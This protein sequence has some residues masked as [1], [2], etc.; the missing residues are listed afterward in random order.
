MKIEFWNRDNNTC[1]VLFE[2]SD[3]FAGKQVR[4][5]GDYTSRGYYFKKTSLQWLVNNGESELDLQPIED[6]VK[7]ELIEYMID[8]AR[9]QGINFIAV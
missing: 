8:K 9:E 7:A 4:F 6:S 2:K 5:K 1:R 3:R